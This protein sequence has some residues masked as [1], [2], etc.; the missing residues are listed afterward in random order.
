MVPKG[1]VPVLCADHRPVVVY[2]QSV[3]DRLV[4]LFMDMNRRLERVAILVAPSNATLLLQLRR[5]VREAAYASRKVFYAC[6]RRFI[7]EAPGA[8]ARA[9]LSLGASARFSTPP[10]RDIRKR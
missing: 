2:P 8:N 7:P 1:T 6:A 10:T 3:A 4:E 9:T 5:L